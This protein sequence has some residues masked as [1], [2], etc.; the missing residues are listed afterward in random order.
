MKEMAV[1]KCIAV[2]S[3]VA[4][5]GLAMADTV[6]LSVSDEPSVVR[7]AALREAIRQ[8][9]TW[10]SENIQRNLLLFLKD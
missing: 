5:V 2:A 4:G 6:V 3:V 1:K 9:T 7:K 8:D 10:T